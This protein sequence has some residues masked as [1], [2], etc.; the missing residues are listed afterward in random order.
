MKKV[1]FLT[2]VVLFAS[3][4]FAEWPAPSDLF[5]FTGLTNRVDLTW[6]P[7]PPIIEADTIGYDDGT[8]AGFADLDS[9]YYVVRFSPAGR[10]SVLAVQAYFFGSLFPRPARLYYWGVNPFGF[11]DIHDYLFTPKEISADL[12]WT[13]IDVSGDGIVFDGSSDFYLGFSKRDT[14]PEF[15]LA[16]DDTVGSVIR[17]YRT[18]GSFNYPTPGDLLVRMVVMFTDTRE[19]RTFSGKSVT[20]IIPFAEPTEFLPFEPLPES[21]RARPAAPLSVTTVD[22]FTIF[23][24]TSFGGP[25]TTYSTVPGS[26]STYSD[27]SV[28]SCHTY[29]YTIRADYEGGSSAMPETVWAT[30]YTGTG[31]TIYDTFYFDDGTPTAAVTF[32]GAVIANKFHVANRCKLIRLIYNVD[33]Y[34]FGVPKVY[35][36]DRGVPGAELLEY[37]TLH[38]FDTGWVDINVDGYDIYLD[39]DFYVGVELDAG[40][41]ISL[42]ATLPGHA[43]DLPPGGTWTQ[44]PDTTYFIR[45]VVRYS[46]GSTY[47]HIYTGWNALS[48]SVIPEVG[49]HPGEVFP[50][51]LGVY[52]WNADIGNWEIPTML[53]PGKGYFILSSSDQFYELEGVP[54]HY[55]NIP[56]AGPGFEFIG[57]LSE[58]GGA[59]T[60]AVTTSP[61]DMWSPRHLY[62]WN[63]AIGTWQNRYKLMP[64]D[65]YFIYLGDEGLFEAEE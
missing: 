33:A 41:G 14:L 16:Y 50:F 47:Y 60:S 27:Y 37:S 58:Y 29:Y 25:L 45:A 12:A 4:A 31:T 65:A 2:L 42:D 21:H 49:L 62:F 5:A 43:W 39:G 18:D 22:S 52:G 36:D 24:G 19:I 6:T 61:P 57:S 59:D 55:Y 53:E 48:L 26:I 40:L 63:P 38:P 30:P 32:P 15:G 34:G 8:A 20:P 44:I 23:R 64:S 46:D 9:G 56:W 35:L 17:S 28:T 51:A 13:N 11:P 1:L 3:A 7:P 10:C 54:I